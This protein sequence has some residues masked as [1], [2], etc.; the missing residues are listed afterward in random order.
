MIWLTVALLA[1]AVFAVTVFVFRL[2]RK[3]WTSFA[4]ALAFGLAGYAWQA[5]PDL[6]SAPK[7]SQESRQQSDHWIQQRHHQQ[8]TA[9]NE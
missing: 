8:S 2:D 4:A 9:E 5:S 7:A 1:L 6:P 3:L